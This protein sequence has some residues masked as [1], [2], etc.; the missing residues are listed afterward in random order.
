MKV[1]AVTRFKQGDIFEAMRRLGWTQAEL[2]R[3]SGLSQSQVG[4]LINMRRRPTEE[5]ANK[6]QKA[7]GKHGE[8]VDVTAVW[9]EAFE[10]FRRIPVMEQTKDVDGEHLLAARGHNPLISACRAEAFEKVSEMLERM[11]DRDRRVLERRYLDRATF[12][13]IAKEESVGKARI[14]EI[15]SRAERRFRDMALEDVKNH[16]DSAVIDVPLA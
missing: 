6:I 9:P 14:C 2:A 3:Q 1:T 12:D 13:V 11:D 10:G 8:Y 15:T 5:I 16:H 4:Y 7:F